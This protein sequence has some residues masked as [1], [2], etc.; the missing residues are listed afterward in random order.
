MY[1]RD[2]QI[3]MRE[4]QADTYGQLRLCWDPI[5]LALRRSIPA[6]C[7][8]GGVR[9]L[10]LELGPEA[11]PKP[12]YRVLLN[13]GLFHYLEFDFHEHL[14]KSEI[15]RTAETLYIVDRCFLALSEQLGGPSGWALSATSA[16]R[17]QS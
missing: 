4:H 7:D 14:S 5:E 16:L 10:V 12:D 1:L 6:K 17:V 8:F 11:D 3:C 15:D 9:K 2:F 13:V